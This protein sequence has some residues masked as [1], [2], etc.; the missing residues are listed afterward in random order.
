MSAVLVNSPA[1]HSRH[2]A[3]QLAAERGVEAWERQSSFV[4]VAQHV[5]SRYAMDDYW[6]RQAAILG[7]PEGKVQVIDALGESGSPRKQKRKFQSLRQRVDERRVGVILLNELHRLSRSFTEAES[8]FESA[9]RNGV[10]FVVG[11]QLLNPAAANDRMVMRTLITVAEHGVQQQTD[12]EM[13]SL[14][15]KA[16][17]LEV[18]LRLPTGLV[19][20]DPHDLNYQTA[21]KRAGLESFLRKAPREHRA[22][23]D[24]KSAHPLFIL[25]LPDSEVIDALRQC[26]EWMVQY[27]SLNAVMQLVR[28]GARGWP[29]DRTGA[30][31]RNHLPAAMGAAWTPKLTTEWRKASLPRLRTWISN[32]AF[33]G[34]YVMYVERLAGPTLQADRRARRSGPHYARATLTAAHVLPD[35]R[36]LLGGPRAECGSPA[37]P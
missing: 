25:P 5:G 27:Q 18:R 37:Q 35:A 23:S 1:P 20:A 22:V 9:A 31:R 36:A 26:Y 28:E 17:R 6:K 13:E 12:Y 30:V 29:R 33:A 14:L 3:V 10:W 15:A 11:G 24:P 32:P 4:Q 8:L 19:W 21:M 7:I 16:R 34:T 2:E